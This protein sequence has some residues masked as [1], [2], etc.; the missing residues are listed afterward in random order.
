[1]DDTTRND[2]RTG[3]GVRVGIRQEDREA[4][5]IYV[6]FCFARNELKDFT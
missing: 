4:P 3:T 5:P 6:I 2:D 1:M